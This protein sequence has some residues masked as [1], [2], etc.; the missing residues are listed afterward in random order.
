[1][2]L[3]TFI[4]AGAPKAGTHSLYDYLRKH[5]DVFM[6]SIKEPRFFAFRGVRDRLRYP[7][8]TLA[9]YEALFDKVTT[10]T[11]VGEASSIYM[12]SPVAAERIKALVPEV[13]LIFSLRE[14]V[15]RTFSIYH[16]NLRTRGANEGKTFLVAMAA[17]HM[18]R[19]KYHE[20]LKPYFGNF[21]RDQIKIKGFS[22]SLRWHSI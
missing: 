16:M 6:P 19:R 1:M 7:I 15:Q 4:V 17:D 20:C 21:S 8:E 12:A 11:A 5:P 10:E 18:L 14:P 22:R 2:T 3:P 9:E 13:K